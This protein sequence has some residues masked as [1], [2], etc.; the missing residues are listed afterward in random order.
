MASA[1]LRDQGSSPGPPRDGWAED[2][3]NLGRYLRSIAAHKKLLALGALVGAIAGAAV[4]VS[5]PVLYEGVSTLLVVAP[6]IERTSAAAVETATFRAI[7][8]NTSLAGEVINELQLNEPPHVLTAYGFVQDAL[9]VEDLRGTNVIRVHVRLRDPVR[10][11][12]ASRRLAR[13]AISLTRR[14]NELEGTSVQEQLQEHVKESAAR[15]TAAEKELL[16]YKQTAQLELLE[17]D[18]E[19]MLDERGE[20]LKLLVEIEGERARLA[21]AETLIKNQSPILEIPRVPGAEEALR[22]TDETKEVLDP[23]NPFVNPVYQ[24]L[25][26]QLATSRARLAGLE[27]QR[28]QILDVNRIG[29]E[30]LNNLRELH[31]RQIELARLQSNFELAKRIHSDLMVRFEE[32]RTRPLGAAPQ[33]QLVDEGVP[34]DRPLSRRTLQST[35]LGLTAGLLAA[36]ALALLLDSRSKRAA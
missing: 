17:R 15:L 20:L 32:S 19:A 34:P 8:E 9:T 35:A 36:A 2:E 1:V 33:L 6:R 24:S 10:A 23:S 11:A 31:N 4:A 12:E 30:Q 16:A 27:R 26:Y 18:T 29:G 21:T 5:R 14:L 13:K 7:L 22:R 28:R 3:L 25:D